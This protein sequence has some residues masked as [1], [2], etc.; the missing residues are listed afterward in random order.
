MMKVSKVTKS[1]SLCPRIQWL[2]LVL[3]LQGQSNWSHTANFQDQLFL[4]SFALDLEGGEGG[5]QLQ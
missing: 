1:C 4:A 3:R 5:P 2:Q